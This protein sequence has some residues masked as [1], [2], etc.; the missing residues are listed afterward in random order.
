MEKLK[1]ETKNFTVTE[2]NR[3]IPKRWRLWEDKVLK[4]RG[5][6]PKMGPLFNSQVKERRKD[7]ESWSFRGRLGSAP[8]RYQKKVGP[9]SPRRF[10]RCTVPDIRKNEGRGKLGE[11]QR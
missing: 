1:S 2:K 7:V 6:Y 8:L 9:L 11:I 10:S 4:I 3:A 5:G